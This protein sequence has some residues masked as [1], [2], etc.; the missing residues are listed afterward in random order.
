MPQAILNQIINQLQALEPS[1][2]QQ[3]NQVLQQYLKDREVT[4][5][6]DAFHQALVGSGLVRQIK[7]PT[8]EQRPHHNLVQ[9]QG[10]P[11]SQTIVEERR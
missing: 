8:F 4:A 5:K 7:H 3:L 11:V 6:S 9:V 2:L 1:E 10:E